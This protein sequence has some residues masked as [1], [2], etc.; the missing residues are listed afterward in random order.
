MVV[1]GMVIL[2]LACVQVQGS[3]E[4]SAGQGTTP[5]AF[6]V[7]PAG[8]DSNPGTEE[9]PWRSIQKA[10]NTAV[11]GSTVF[12]KEGVY[13]EKVI[14]SVS[15]N[16]AQGYITFRAFPGQRV[17]IDGSGVRK[18][19][20]TF[21]DNIIYIQNKNYIRI[22]GFEITGAAV[23]DG[24]G[25]RVYDSADHISIEHNKIYGIRGKSAMGITAYGKGGQPIRNLEI[26]GNEIHNCEPAPSE[27]V[28]LNGNVTD[29]SITD[30]SIHD[31]NNIG[32]DMIGG[33]TWLS[34]QVVRNGVCSGNTVFRARSAY[35]DGYAAGIYVDGANN[36]IIE[37]NRVFECDL[38]V[39]I[40]AENSG[41]LVENI[42]V[43]NNLVYNNDKAGIAIG[44]FSLKGGTVRGCTVINN[45]LYRNNRV[46]A[47]GEVWIQYASGVEVINNIIVSSADK[48]GD[49]FLLSCLENP[50]KNSN[51]FDYNLYFVEKPGADADM[52][53]IARKTYNGLAA[54]KK[55][56]AQ[57][58]HSVY[59]DPLF[60][61]LPQ[62][63]KGGFSPAP[64]SPARDT[65][66]DHK[67]RG[68]YDFYGNARLRG[69]AVDRGAVEL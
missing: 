53:L 15:G 11:P 49:A 54:Y 26:R 20:N 56:T 22:M 13:K 58:A 46:K 68:E 40:G 10:A 64:A 44:A 42:T 33:E 63:D 23:N 60:A 34:S 47:E 66:T 30:N 50:A 65:G 12:I 24:S 7:A 28:T 16:A 32:I 57:D 14:I 43:R 6:Y 67:A 2:C 36:I 18:R 4:E 55:A 39:E 37:R 1:C 41:V 35:E 21:G 69:A 38:G 29:F 5:P 17:V 19:R 62:A 59:T 8:N 25:I 45:T 3:G 27:A 31:V 9:K 61:S 52:F 51:R 48:Q